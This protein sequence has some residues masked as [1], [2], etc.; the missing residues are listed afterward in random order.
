MGRGKGTL[1]DGLICGQDKE[2][3]KMD[4]GIDKR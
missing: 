2:R 3:I 1:E 4:R